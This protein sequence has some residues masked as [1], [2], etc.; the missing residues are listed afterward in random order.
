MK[1]F[2]IAAFIIALSLSPVRAA[3]GAS[4]KI[5]GIVIQAGT[6]RPID[7]VQIILS[8]VSPI[9]GQANNQVGAVTDQFGRFQVENV[10]SGRYRVQ[11][12]RPGYFTPP[13]G[14]AGPD[15]SIIQSLKAQ[16]GIASLFIASPPAATSV[17][18]D[19]GSQEN[20][21]GFVFSLIPGGVISGRVFDPMGN[22]VVNIPL[23]ALTL[24]Y[25][26]GHKVLRPGGSVATSDDRGN[27]RL[28]GLR[29]GEY[30]I[31]ADY[32]PMM[33]AVR[34]YFP[35][36]TSLADALPI[37]VNENGESPGANF[38]IPPGGTVKI[39]GTVNGP[40]NMVRANTQFS[41]WH[42]DTEQLEDPTTVS[43]PNTAN[44][45]NRTIGEFELRSVP[46][47]RFTLVA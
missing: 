20:L 34:V 9:Q 33:T 44:S 16:L 11:W 36:V 45:E 14:T 31:R 38:S 3:Q 47:G 22:P 40:A 5:S 21:E 43:I 27:F 25:E 7:G 28:F 6:A 2:L 10:Q 29:P 41:I 39:T 1:P 42:V 26:D 46:P 30:Y 12:T 18:V 17:T 8:S 13:L 23:T 4:G 37:V 32:R 35:G 15:S 24:R 19:V